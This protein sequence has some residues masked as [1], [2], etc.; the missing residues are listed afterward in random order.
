MGKFVLVDPIPHLFL[1][2]C[3]LLRFKFQFVDE[4][5]MLLWLRFCEDWTEDDLCEKGKSLLARQYSEFCARNSLGLHQ[6]NQ[7]R[8]TDIK[9]KQKN[10]KFFRE[11]FLVRTKQRKDIQAF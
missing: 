4:T 6:E 8:E 9:Q 1:R 10:W 2:I 11:F 3:L 7:W 5:P